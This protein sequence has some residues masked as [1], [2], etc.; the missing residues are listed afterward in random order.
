MWPPCSSPRARLSDLRTHCSHPPLPCRCLLP[1]LCALSSLLHP[2]PCLTS[3]W[4]APPSCHFHLGLW[5]Q[6]GLRDWAL[7]LVWKHREEGVNVTRKQI[8]CWQL[9]AELATCEGR[10]GRNGNT[11]KEM[12]RE[13][14]TQRWSDYPECRN[15]KEGDRNRVRGENPEAQNGA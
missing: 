1:H 14:L 12:R 13:P 5:P 6:E 2:L 9:A 8:Q 3:A 4:K 11:G 7:E 10:E 15:Q